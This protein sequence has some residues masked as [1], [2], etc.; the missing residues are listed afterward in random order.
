[1]AHLGHA[2]RRRHCP[3]LACSGHEAAS[4]LSHLLE[5][6]LKF[7]FSQL[8]V[9]GVLSSDVVILRPPSE[10]LP[11]E[12]HKIKVG[13]FH[14][15]WL[16]LYLFPTTLGLSFEVFESERLTGNDPIDRFYDPIMDRG[17]R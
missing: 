14:N 4:A 6:T 17:C 8:A 15:A 5:K 13:T 9:F 16:R 10:R 7:K 3:L 1:M 2:D 11:G 12:K